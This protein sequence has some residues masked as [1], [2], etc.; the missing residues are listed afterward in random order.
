[1]YRL[2]CAF[3][4]SIN[5]KKSGKLVFAHFKAMKAQSSFCQCTDSPVLSL[6][7]SMRKNRKICMF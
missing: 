7:A 1:M 6:L 4:A 3:A 5:E 2:A